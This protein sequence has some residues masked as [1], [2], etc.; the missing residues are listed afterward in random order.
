VHVP[1]Y[2]IVDDVPAAD[3]IAAAT[4]RLG[5]GRAPGPTG[6][7]AEDIKKWLKLAERED[8]PDTEKW[9]AVVELVQH[10]FSNGGELPQ[11][12]TWAYLVILPKA[13]GGY[14][15]IGLLEVVWKIISSIIQQR[16]KAKVRYHDIIHGFTSARGTGTA[17][18]ELKLCQEL[19][20][21]AQEP[22]HLIF[23]DLKK[24]YDTVDRPRL[25]DLLSQYGVGPNC[26][27]LLREFWDRQQTVAR[28]SGYHGP[29]FHPERGQTQGD[30]FSSEGFNILVDAVVREWLTT[31]VDCDGNTV[32]NGF[33]IS[34][35]HRLSMFYADD[36][37][38]GA[39]D[40]PWL[41]NALD[42]LTDL[43]RRTGLATNASKTVAM[44]CSPGYIRTGISTQAYQRRTTGVGPTHR[45][46]QRE[47]T[48]CP[49]CGRQFARSSLS[50]H[51]LSKHGVDPS[52]HQTPAPELLP[53]HH[54]QLYT[55]DWA[56]IEPT[57]ACPVPFCTGSARHW[58]QLRCH[59]RDR[60]PQDR[61]HIRNE[62]PDPL[63]Q[64]HR[65]NLQLS[66]SQTRHIGRQDCLR[67]ELKKLQRDRLVTSYLAGQHPFQ[68]AGQQLDK[69]LSFRYLGR[70]IAASNSDWPALYR[71]LQRARQQWAY[72]AR[73]LANDGASPRAAGMFYKAIVQSVL[74][75]G[76]ETWVL[77]EPMLKVLR[78]FH[79]RVAR[80]ITNKQPYLQNG[81][82]I[83]PPLDEALDAANLEPIDEYIRRRQNHIAQYL[84]T[85]P[86]LQ[87][88]TA[89]PIPRGSVSRLRWWT[90][91]L[92][93]PANNANG[94]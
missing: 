3:E 26:I 61:I 32:T 93:D 30:V 54:P 75:Y 56:R 90:S 10:C 73:P 40:A 59:F 12:L 11:E 55:I 62:S 70:I 22:L 83:Y 5:N 34:I 87:L 72:I 74:L 81:D 19:A 94:N 28:Q 43:F 18:I 9:D 16:I 20:S 24:A 7:K 78:G 64:C 6:L 45:Q 84:A 4:R 52:S 79:H 36:G 91:Q 80:R 71:N 77:T 66:P 47:A 39:R 69:V 53:T 23:L 49:D 86:V 35:A 25:L 51:R 63:P 48:L 76:C 13:D 33:G 58:Y 17:I 67:H 42:I 92:P 60:H 2:D 29:A 88:C 65:C 82:W 21:I 1:A 46:R 15:G 57:K 41:Q 31:I 85:R 37:V 68:A 44:T 89:A 14:R 38:I 27:R 50:N 8:D